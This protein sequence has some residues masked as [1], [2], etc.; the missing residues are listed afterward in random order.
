MEETT[1]DNS[2]LEPALNA[3]LETRY[4]FYFLSSSLVVFLAGLISILTWRIFDHVVG[5]SERLAT[6]RHI[7]NKSTSRPL[8]NSST[9]IRVGL[10]TKIKWRCEKLISGQ[11]FFGRVMVSTVKVPEESLQQWGKVWC[12]IQTICQRR[13]GAYSG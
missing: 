1:D 12:T 7:R 3:C 2:T 11:S 9:N 8:D 5:C 10:A 13:R 4:W 6:R